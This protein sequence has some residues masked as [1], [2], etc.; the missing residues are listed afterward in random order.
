MTVV[1]FAPSPFNLPLVAIKLVSKVLLLTITPLAPVSIH[2]M[3]L[4]VSAMKLSGV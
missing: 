3:K 2:I 1:G 4:L